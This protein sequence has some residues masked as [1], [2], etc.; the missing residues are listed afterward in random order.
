MDRKRRGAENILKGRNCS[1]ICTWSPDEGIYEPKSFVDVS[2]ADLDHRA[3]PD[4]FNF[5]QHLS[6]KPKNGYISEHFAMIFP[7]VFILMC[8]LLLLWNMFRFEFLQICFSGDSEYHLAFAHLSGKL[9][10][11]QIKR[12]SHK[13]AQKCTGMVCWF[14]TTITIV[15]YLLTKSCVLLCAHVAFVPLGWYSQ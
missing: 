2:C 10:F 5:D 15:R 9:P 1:W 13:E 4:K 7:R 6:V 3:P 8:S 12:P 14:V 11:L